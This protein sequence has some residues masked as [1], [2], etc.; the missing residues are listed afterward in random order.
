MMVMMMMVVVVKMKGLRLKRVSNLDLTSQTPTCTWA[1]IDGVHVVDRNG[2][3]WCR[4][5]GRR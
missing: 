1:R 5:R 4:H 2:A 3:S